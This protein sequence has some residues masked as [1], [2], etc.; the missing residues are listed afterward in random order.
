[1]P[2]RSLTTTYHD[3]HGIHGRT[4]DTHQQGRE[5]TQHD[6]QDCK[7]H[8]R[9]H[10]ER[11]SVTYLLVSG[12]FDG[13][14]D[15]TRQHVQQVHRREYDPQRR[16]H[17]LH[18]KRRVH[19][20]DAHELGDEDCEP[21]QPHRC[22]G[23]EGQEPSC[24]RHPGCQPA[25]ILD[26][27]RPRA[28]RYYADEDEKEGGVEP[29]RYLLE[30][31]PVEA[32]RVTRGSTEQDETQSTYGGVGDERL[33]VWLQEGYES[34]V[35]DVDHPE[36]GDIREERFDALGKQGDGHRDQAVGPKLGQ[37]TGEQH[38]GR[39]RAGD[40]HVQ[41]PA[42]QRDGGHLDEQPEE[43]EGGHGDLGRLRE[44]ATATEV[45]HR[46]GVSENTESQESGQHHRRAEERID[47]EFDRGRTPVFV[48]PHADEQVHGDQ[49]D[50]EEDVEQDQIL[51]RE[52][53][54]HPYL[55][56]EDRCEVLLEVSLHVPRGENRNDREESREEEHPEPE[57]SESDAVAYVEGP[58]PGN[59]LGE[60]G[61][62]EVVPEGE[63]DVDREDKR[64][65]RNSE[66]R[67]AQQALLLGQEKHQYRAEQR[68]EDGYRGYHSLVP[69]AK[70]AIVA[71]AITPTTITAYW[72]PTITPMIK[73]LSRI[74]SA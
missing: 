27:A 52:D 36:S 8:D 3:Q 61:D 14:E 54:Q 60:R 35:D 21:G 64:H 29:V 65:G 62:A 66:G 39:S 43:D 74:K 57:T 41:K 7:R 73:T 2:A 49:R 50:L 32:D 4:L 53:T 9:S 63:V 17:S 25:E 16:E 72:A 47:E 59:V 34:P 30:D 38:V 28:G 10:L 19:A 24:P 22:E 70:A 44:A 71:R 42:V 55:G 56:D 68:D 46:V 11:P 26:A 15:H 37:N 23:T 18:R 40:I 1:M 45:V 33:E 20:H 31:G 51:R 69:T 13:A 5:D 67:V 6:E 12:T 48:P 58:D